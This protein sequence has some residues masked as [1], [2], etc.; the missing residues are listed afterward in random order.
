MFGALGVPTN[1]LQKSFD[2][3]T[4]QNGNK[5]GDKP[6]KNH[7]ASNWL[8]VGI[9]VGYQIEY[10]QVGRIIRAHKATQTSEICYQ[11]LAR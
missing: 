3:R 2:F 6:L 11:S 1:L 8:W 10:A 4:A 7:D 9:F 5:P